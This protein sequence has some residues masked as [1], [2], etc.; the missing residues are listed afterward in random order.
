MIDYIRVG[1]RIK[2]VRRLK[3][4]TREELADKAGIDHFT[5][6]D[7]ERGTCDKY[8]AINAVCRALD[9]DTEYTLDPRNKEAEE[10]AWANLTDEDLQRLQRVAEFLK[11]KNGPGA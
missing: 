9:I 4:W 5:V 8:D 6:G 1:K 7:I 2:T 11:Q 10:R 3:G